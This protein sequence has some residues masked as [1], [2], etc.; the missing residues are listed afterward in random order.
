MEWTRDY[1]RGYFDGK[2]FFYAPNPSPD[3]VDPHSWPFDQ[4]FYLKLNLAI[5]GS[6]GGTPADVNHTYE[7]RFDWVRVYQ[8]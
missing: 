1:I 5:G 3:E 8:K 2:E 4:K 7:T 6:W